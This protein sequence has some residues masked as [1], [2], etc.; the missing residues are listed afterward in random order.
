MDESPLDEFSCVFDSTAE[1]TKLTG[2]MQM[3][4]TG[5][6]RLAEP[7]MAA[8]LRHEMTAAAGVL[9]DLLENRAAAI[10][11]HPAAR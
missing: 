7:L 10:S 2:K 8:S 11:P 4:A 3:Q 9:K 1:G 6:L 5:L